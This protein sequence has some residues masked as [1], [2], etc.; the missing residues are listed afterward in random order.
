MSDKLKD[1]FM[2]KIEQLE[3]GGQLDPFMIER[4]FDESLQENSGKGKGYLHRY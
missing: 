4:A 3:K 1:K 2:S